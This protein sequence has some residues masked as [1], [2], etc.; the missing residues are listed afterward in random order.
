MDPGNANSKQSAW[1][2]PKKIASSVGIVLLVAA[3]YGLGWYHRNHRYDAFAQCMAAKQ[4]KMYGAYWC[5]HCADQKEMLGRSY[6]FVYEE[7]GVPGSH[8]EQK[9]CSDLGVKLFPTW[10]FSDGALAPGVFSLRDL[11]LRSECNL[12]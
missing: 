12:P 5:S 10:Q 7:C 8:E 2:A 1:P 9:K 3:A 4:V 11:S 6:R